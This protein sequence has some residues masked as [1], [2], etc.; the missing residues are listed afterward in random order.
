[1]YFLF[2][3]EGPTDLGSGRSGLEIHEHLDGHFEPGPVAHLV[4]QTI[5]A[6][7][8]FSPLESGHCGFVSESSL[9]RRSEQLNPT[10]ESVVL[11]GMKRPRETIYFF[12]N[13]RA[14]A[15]IARDKRSSLGNEGEQV[16]AILFRD[17]DGTA[18]ASRGNWADKQDSIVRGFAAEGWGDGV[19]MLA[20][21]KSEAWLLCALQ[22]QPYQDCE[23]WERAAGNDRSPH[24]L[25]AQLE[26][27]L[28]RPATREHLCQ[29]VIDRTI[30]AARIDM[31]S[32]RAFRKRL[33]RVIATAE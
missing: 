28:G 6:V 5:H 1:M 22:D 15:R 17:A 20:N 3:G 31:P 32:F 27:R 29:L 18:S 24:A 4:D 16:V 11:R 7:L 13:A 23:K 14:L 19:P 21:P 12:N 9:S 26:E 30:D 2:S 10:K 33:D 25:K 8:G